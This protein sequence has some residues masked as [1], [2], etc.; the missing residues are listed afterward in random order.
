MVLDRFFI[1]IAIKKYW[2]FS[3]RYTYNQSMNIRDYSLSD[4]LLIQLGQRLQYWFAKPQSAVRKSPGDSYVERP[5]STRQRRHSAGLMRINHAGE[6]CAQALYEG[7]ALTAKNA[8]IRYAMQEAAAEEVDHLAWC[9]ARLDALGSH[10]SYANP[11]WYVGAFSLGVIAGFC[12]DR[13]SLGFLAETERQ[14]SAH[15]AEHL[16][17][18]PAN[19]LK[20]RAILTQMKADEEAHATLA[21]EQGAY[22][23]PV[24]I[25][26]GMRLASK[27]MVKVAY[28]L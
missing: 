27:V 12:G 4:Q 19:D 5:L 13:W 17:Q 26:I 6:V 10:V 2:L 9:F 7:Q 23:L 25:K 28:Y 3:A 20:S 21:V 24:P 8:K 11:L 18:L 1:K 22:A 15:I 16:M 14:V